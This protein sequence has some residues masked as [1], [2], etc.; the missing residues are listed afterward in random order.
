[1]AKVGFW[2]RGAKGKL[3]GA[4]ISNSPNGTV[5][6]TIVT[7]KNPR[8][9][10]QMAQRAIFATVAKAA[11]AMKFIIDHS[12]ENVADGDACIKEFRK[13]N[14][15]K[16]R[17]RVAA[18]IAAE[19]GPDEMAAFVAP[20]G[21]PY[22]T[23]NSYIVS[24]GS[25]ESPSIKIDGKGLLTQIVTINNTEPTAQEFVQA[26]LGILPGE[27]LT[28]LTIEAGFGSLYYSTGDGGTGLACYENK[29]NARRLVFKPLAENETEWDGIVGATATAIETSLEDVL[30]VEKS[31]LTLLHDLCKE[32]TVTSGEGTTT[33]TV[34]N[35]VSFSPDMVANGMIRSK[36]KLDGSWMYSN[37]SMNMDISNVLCGLPLDEAVKTYTSGVSLG[38]DS[39]PF[40][41]EGGQG[42]SSSNI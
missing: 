20:K 35:R 38:T 34:A 14:L 12:F 42:G 11:S 24:R 23:P 6:R 18:D 8:S 7:P 27:Q 1:M 30:V 10:K 39:A 22:V 36:Q 15:T 2:L 33:F 13:L 29:F 17:N 28:N 3:A 25:L 40:L 5:M 26:F 21:Y 19:L 37:S 32:I 41:D 9:D 16:L 31:D 4:S